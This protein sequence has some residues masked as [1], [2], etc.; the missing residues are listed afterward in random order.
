MIMIPHVDPERKLRFS[1]AG[2]I[3]DSAVHVVAALTCVLASV[4]IS[5]ISP[6]CFGI[7]ISISSLLLGVSGGVDP[8]AGEVS[9]AIERLHRSTVRPLG[10]YKRSPPVEASVLE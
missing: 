4:P 8:N 9:N 3:L 1:T 10:I 7:A 5:L 2:H 6:A